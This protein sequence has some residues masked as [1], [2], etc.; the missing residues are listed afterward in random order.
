MRPIKIVISAFGPYAE[1][2]PAIDFEQ[3][4]E[5]GLFL[6]AG[7]TGAGKTTI[8]DAICFALYG[9]TSGTY[10]DTKNLRSEY[11]K[12]SVESYVDFYFTHQGKQYHVWRRPAYERKKLRGTGTVSEKEKAVLYEEEKVPVE[13]LSNVNN[14]VIELLG[15]NEK[16]FKQIAMIAQGEF[17]ALL[18]AK[19]E[20]RTE[21]LR[22]IFMTNAYKAIEFRL[23]DR[24]D[25]SCRKKMAAE[26]SIV[27]YFGDVTADEKDE[28]AAELGDLQGRA[29]RAGS[30]FEVGEMLQLIGEILRADRERFTALEEELGAETEK[31]DQ[32][33]A[34]LAMAEANNGILEKAVSLRAEKAAIEAR[35]PEIEALAAL[36]GRQKDARRKV[37]PL[38]G[39]WAGKAADRSATEK[40]IKSNASL[41]EAA[42]DNAGK[43]DAVL[44]AAEAQKGTAE[45]QQKKAD[46]ISG[47]ES[48]YQR[49]EELRGA[50]SKYRKNET[51]LAESGAKIERAEKALGERIAAL[52]ESV[53]ALKD[54]PEEYNQA[55]AKGESLRNLLNKMQ[56]ITEELIPER[57]EK[58]KAYRK[59]ADAF[60]KARD[61]YTE[62]AGARERAER[63][64]EDCRAGILAAGLSE[65]Q[66]CP[67][68]GSVHHPEPARLPLE[69]VTE[70]EVKKCKETENRLLEKKND[71]LA[72]AESAKT[73][74]A[75]SNEWLK[76]SAIECLR[77]PVLNKADRDWEAD[78][79]GDLVG[80]FYE[81][82]KE[83]EEG[84]DAANA[85]LTALNKDCLKLKKDREALDLAQGEETEKL[86]QI[87][88]N[89]LSGKQSNEK[90][91]VE[92]E[93]ALK[94]IGELP[95]ADWASA[96]KERDAAAREAEKILDGI[97]KVGKVK[98]KADRDVAALQ[99]AIGTLKETLAAQK[100]EEADL[101][102]ELDSALSEHGFSSD[103]EMRGYAV[104]EKAIAESD[105]I[106]S[107]YYRKAET[108]RA[109]LAE[110]EEEAKG[111]EPADTEAL[112]AAILEKEAAVG[113]S[114]KALGAIGYRVRT[115]EE[116][117]ENITG[118]REVLEEAR[119]RN[120]IHT[121][122]YNL[123][124]GQTG[125]GKITLE[126]YIQASGF[127]SIIAAANRRLLP[128]S[129]G[130][131][132][133]FRQE[134]SLG[135]RSNTFLNLEVLDNYTGQRRPVGNLS[136]GESFKASL[137]LALGL[138]D[139]VSSNLG[140]IQ[141]DA[142]FVDEGFG[143]LD[144]KSI[145]NAMDILVGLSGTGKLVGIISHREELMEN[146]PQQI[147]V[148]KTKSGSKIEVC[149]NT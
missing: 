132:E 47:E 1:T 52:K 42:Q 142:L 82:Q 113:E 71:A 41:L 5:Q 24:M 129:D 6:V 2:M 3:F 16:Q 67:V 28:L 100:T 143:T 134:D 121:R 111:R 83:T 49:R 29:A 74:L 110:A 120:T 32:R 26:N 95:F 54:R 23:K 148:R 135:K 115:N 127:D 123:V 91:V 117:L 106:I 141:M 43:A 107:G 9:T 92:C 96:R 101:R 88:E 85:I 114:R 69:S 105:E 72:A 140:G 79:L 64:L 11:A 25:E 86:R 138:S 130:Q 133:L 76:S 36:L 12:D 27:Q 19:T 59:A 8:F 57:E 136:G 84:L 35:R 48:L 90:A 94:A 65:G 112:K 97:D 119:R 139:T 30:A 31:L 13:G 7:D 60:L 21:I 37:F 109:R 122:L 50:L 63:I 45:A 53:E 33:K 118:Q 61:L 46:K 146:I 149:A 62:A 73:A 22:T 78:T 66:K 93:T 55:W 75:G 17:W 44:K 137:S 98:Q 58:R 70:D 125:N 87:R 126:Q 128:M 145:E 34:E 20:E 124:K 39:T 80:H 116:K 4:E 108:N 144:R 102:A 10:R 103:E 68:C 38:Y 81:A 99:A 104:T 51:V 14:A 89:Y 131:F 56:R 40:K 15:I 18:N 147:R 77:S